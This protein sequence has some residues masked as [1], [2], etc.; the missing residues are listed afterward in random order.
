M[1]GV[2]LRKA[3]HHT[4]LRN[5]VM[6]TSVSGLTRNLH[7]A[8]AS[9]ANAVGASSV[10]C[11]GASCVPEALSTCPWTQTGLEVLILTVRGR[12]P[13]S[14]EPEIG[15][16]LPM[17]SAPDAGKHLGAEAPA[18]RPRSRSPMIAITPQSNKPASIPGRGV[19]QYVAA[20]PEEGG[21]QGQEWHGKAAVGAAAP[22]G[23]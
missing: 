13:S 2:R 18:F 3:C 6:H 16:Q 21:L 10:S 23:E 17:E 11:P 7:G 4:K 12:Q 5:I 15:R 9:F 22:L 20:W 8:D 19:W 1:W 14:V